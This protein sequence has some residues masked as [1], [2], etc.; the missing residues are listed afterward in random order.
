MANKTFIWLYSIVTLSA[1]SSQAQVTFPSELEHDL[2]C[3]ASLLNAVYDARLA[4]DRN[5]SDTK[6]Q[7]YFR[8]RSFDWAGRAVQEG[9]KSGL[10][11]QQ[12]EDAIN[13]R[14]GK[15]QSTLEN[16]PSAGWL[17]HVQDAM[18]QCN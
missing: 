13:E 16:G 5:I 2:F 15:M 17:S 10:T 7:E 12:V 18:K 3:A 4:G 8:S 11:M 14:A 9:K 1:A 6:V